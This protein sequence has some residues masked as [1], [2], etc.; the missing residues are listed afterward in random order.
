MFV[1]FKSMVFFRWCG[2]ITFLVDKERKNVKKYFVNQRK[3]RN[4]AAA[5]R[6]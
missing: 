4:F 1:S 2:K 6:K 5:Y 3:S